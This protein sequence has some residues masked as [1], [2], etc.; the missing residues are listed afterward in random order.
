LENFFSYLSAGTELA[1][2][3]PGVALRDEAVQRSYVMSQQMPFR[4]RSWWE[5][6]AT[7]AALPG[8]TGYSTNLTLST[9]SAAV[10]KQQ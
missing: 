2:N 3:H 5:A 4:A 8:A 1:S 6:F 10:K 9:A 7:A